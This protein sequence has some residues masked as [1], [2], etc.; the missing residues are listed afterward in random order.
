M[1]FLNAVPEVIA[2]LGDAKDGQN[3]VEDLNR[4][5]KY[6]PINLTGN[7]YEIGVGSVKIISAMSMVKDFDTYFDMSACFFPP[8]CPLHAPSTQPRDI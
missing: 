3:M 1:L 7:P 6:M 2:A 4:V 5:M 8:P